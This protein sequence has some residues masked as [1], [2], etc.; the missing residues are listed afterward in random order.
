MKLFSIEAGRFKLDGGA[1]F[2]VVP[3][4]IWS[5]AHPSDQKNMI[6][7]AS[8]CLLIK[9]KKKLILIDSGMGDKQSKKFFSHYYRQGK[10][11]VDQALAKIG[12]HRDD[13][14]DVFFTHLHF[15]HCGGAVER[16]PTSKNLEL[17][18][19]NAKYWSNEKQWRWAIYPN[20]REKASF[21]REN[22]IPIENSGQLNFIDNPKNNLLKNSPLGFDVFFANGHTEQQMIPII[23]YKN[24]T[25]CFMGDLIPTAA[26][27]PIPYVAAYD[28]RPLV[29]LKE[30]EKFLNLALKNNYYL[31][32]EHDPYHEI[33][34]LK[35][36]E[37]GVRVNKSF[38]LNSL[39]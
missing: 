12:F 10:Q 17:V 14:T 11:G 20:K 23:K 31:F 21:L 24:A 37:K 3:K 39:K 19:K 15:D 1:M 29:S 7:I 4:T 6:D 28:I 22:I 13:I 35:R 18:F 5:K 2:G 16:C 9:N 36:T 32:L 33:V 34:S 27:I 30:K 8:R 26:H 25:I 38:N